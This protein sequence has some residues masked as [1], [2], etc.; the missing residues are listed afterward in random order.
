MHIHWMVPYKAN[1]CYVDWK[2]KMDATTGIF[3]LHRTLWEMNKAFS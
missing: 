3:F 1:I 2:S